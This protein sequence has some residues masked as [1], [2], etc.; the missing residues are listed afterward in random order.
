MERE[1]SGALSRRNLLKGAAAAGVGV[2]VWS[3]PSITSIGGTPAY[4]AVCTKGFTNY[5]LGSRNT[6]CSCGDPQVQKYADFKPLGT[7]CAGDGSTFTGS[8][9]LSV[10][11]GGPAIPESGECPQVAGGNAGVTVTS[12]PNPNLYCR[13]V[14]RIWQGGS[15]GGSYTE[16]V[17]PIFQG[18]TFYPLPG[19]P[20]QGGGN[21]F[22]S[23]ILRCSL[24]QGCL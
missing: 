18:P 6:S 11:P 8:A 16:V 22:I 7:P 14:V 15:C 3:S 13:T 4:A 1:F 5:A 12:L 2:A 20:C 17:G 9:Y 10:G 23:V 21:I 19:V 24:Q